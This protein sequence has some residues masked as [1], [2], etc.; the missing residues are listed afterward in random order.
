MSRIGA[1][2]VSYHP[3]VEV[4]D[5]LLRSLLRQVELLI[6]VDNGG[7]ETFLTT[8]AVA[9][10]S[11]NYIAL[12]ANLGL[13]AALN[14][15]FAVAA[16][17]GLDFL[18]TFDQDSHANADLIANLHQSMQCALSKDPKC[19]AVGPH[20]F[21]RREGEKIPFPFYVSDSGKIAPAFSTTSTDGLLRVDTLITSGMLV[22]VP[23]WVG[24]MKYDEGMFVDYTDTEWCFR[25]RSCGHTLYGCLA[26]EMGHALSD[27]PP[28]KFMGLSFFEY[29]PVRRYFYFRNTMAVI[30]MKHT[31]AAW[32][33]RLA[34]GLL[35]RFFVNIIIDKQRFK[36]VGMM[37][38][39]VSHGLAG[40]LGG[41]R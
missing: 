30:R 18:V 6:L 21:D 13:G 28:V 40:K 32:K 24:G 8:D 17:K 39:G 25:A 1:V 26:V 4:L 15:A 41:L 29:S 31:P 37:I 36:S 23:A 3:D 33:K 12:G 10:Q 16:E 11:I 19:I 38:R 5:D 14:K 35:L 7:G 9:R 34:Q 20:F 2:V 27:A 22:S